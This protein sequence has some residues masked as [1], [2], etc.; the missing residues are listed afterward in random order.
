MGTKVK[1]S[2][3]VVGVGAL[4]ALPGAASAKTRSGVT[5][6]NLLGDQLKGFVFSPKPHQCADGRP[7]KVFRQRGGGQNPNRDVKVGGTYASARGNGKYR[8]ELSLHRPS[9]GDYYARVPATA[10]CQAD[11]S[12]A[13]HISAR[14]D[15]RIRDVL[16]YDDRTPTFYYYAVGGVEPYRFQCKLD[17]QRFRGCK[18]NSKRYH[19]LSRGRHVFKVRAIGSN[20]KKDAT[21]EKRGFHIPHK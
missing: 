15:T 6:H 9:P 1:V 4:L 11:N 8:W 7:V 21:P 17:D 18:G 2:L 10:A 16:F 20:G 5:I 19:D 12:K 3:A 13:V 14:P